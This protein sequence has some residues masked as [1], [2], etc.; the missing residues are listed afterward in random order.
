MYCPNYRFFSCRRASK[1]LALCVWMAAGG[2]GRREKSPEPQPDADPGPQRPKKAS[3]PPATPALTQWLGPNPS[4]LLWWRPPHRNAALLTDLFAFPARAA[5]LY[6]ATQARVQDTERF[7][8]A[9]LAQSQALAFEHQGAFLTLLRVGPDTYKRLAQRVQSSGFALHEHHEWGCV[10]LP[11]V[12]PQTL[13]LLDAPDLAWVDRPRQASAL[14]AL[15]VARDL[16]PSA[17]RRTLDTALAQTPKPIALAYGYAPSLH[18][19]LA[20]DPLA[21]GFELHAYGQP[22]AQGQS[23]WKGHMQLIH[24]S[25][26]QALATLRDPSALADHPKAQTLRQRAHLGKLGPQSLEIRLEVH[27]DDPALSP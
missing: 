3:V 17:P 11:A 22:N 23:G 25:P 1:F 9:P 7:L 4:H 19:E 10:D 21:F 26:E 27:G 6:A 13:C 12:Y 20:E 5:S 2:C 15:R 8:G 24:P 18:L 16:P 14:Q